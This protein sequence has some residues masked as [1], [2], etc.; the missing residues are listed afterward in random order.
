MVPSVPF[1]RR[2]LVALVVLLALAAAVS[3]VA[4]SARADMPAIPTVITAADLVEPDPGPIPLDDPSLASKIED[5]FVWLVEKKGA[6]LDHPVL[7]DPAHRAAIREAGF[8]AG[9]RYDL[10]PDLLWSIAYRESTFKL[11]EVGKRGEQGL[12]QVGERGR[13]YCSAACGTMTTAAEQ[14][15]CGACWLDAG[16]QWCGGSLL[17]GLYAYAGGKCA[18]GTP[19][20]VRVVYLRFRVWRKIRALV[21]DALPTVAALL[22]PPGGAVRA[23]P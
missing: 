5:A 9:A 20:I 22:G 3:V 21:Y 13:R 12:M 10:P 2:G 11:D 23:A 4:L 1:K 14:I 7:A 15:A 6:N 19:K 18:A 8:V 16:R 17:R